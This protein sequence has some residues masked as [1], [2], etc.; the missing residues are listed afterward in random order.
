MKNEK[1]TVF[2]FNEIR[3]QTSKALIIINDEQMIVKLLYVPT[4]NVPLCV[5]SLLI[6]IQT[7]A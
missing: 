5:L 2:L 6:Q 3:Y 1:Y 7:K 4:P